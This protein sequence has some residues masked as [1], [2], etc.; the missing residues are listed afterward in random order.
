MKSTRRPTAKL[1]SANSSVDTNSKRVFLASFKYYISCC[2]PLCQIK[3]LLASTSLSEVAF[4]MDTSKETAEIE[5]K[6]PKHLRYYVETI[7]N[8]PFSNS[9]KRHTQKNERNVCLFSPGVLNSRP[10]RRTSVLLLPSA[11]VT[12]ISTSRS[13]TLLRIVV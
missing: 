1:S 6:S 2:F 3:L 12:P 9:R 5:T 7:G 13:L 11:L 8:S 10:K 4:S